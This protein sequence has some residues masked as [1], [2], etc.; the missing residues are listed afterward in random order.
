MQQDKAGRYVAN[1][2]FIGVG[3]L[4]VQVLLGGITRLTGSGLSITEWKPI[5]GTLPPL[6]DAEWQ[7]TFLDYQQIA[8]FKYLNQHFTLGDFKFIFFWEWF[9]RV[10]ARL[11]GVVFLIPFIYFLA[12]GYFKKW[13][14]A[15]LIILF[16]L[17]GLQGAIGWIMVKSGLND[18]DLYVSHFRLAAHFMA[19]MVLISYAVIFGL[20]LTVKKTNL[21]TQPGLKN[22]AFLI[23]LF[24]AVQLT[25]GAFMAGLKAANVAPTWPTINGMLFPDTMFT[26]G[27]F[28]NDILHN[29]ITIHFIHRTL[30]Y[31][32]VVL[33]GAWWWKARNITYSSPFNKAKNYAMLFVVVQVVLGIMAVLTSPGMQAGK[34]GTFEWMAQLHQLVGML[35]LLS[36]VAI[37]YIT[38]YN[39][40]PAT[41]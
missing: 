28:L 23:I 36:F 25:Y 14:V 19:A 9:H 31:I 37:L 2:I 26:S 30:A 21:I 20:K 41:I 11:I 39:K 10:W 22:G 16:V 5:M 3:M 4:I 40:I 12:K 17:G 15:P 35:L 13:M 24:L 34:F 6:N 32:L 1:W 27:S 8:Q 38:R 7:K 33:I 29:K 18:N